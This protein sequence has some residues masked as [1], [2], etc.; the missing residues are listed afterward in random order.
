MGRPT[1]GYEFLIVD[2]ESGRLCDE[3]QPGELWVRGT[4]GIQLFLEY[5]DNPGAMA[6][7]FT[8]EG[9]F[10]TGDV[11]RIGEGGGFFFCERDKDLIKVGGE[12]VSAREVEDVIRQVP[13]LS[14]VAVVSRSHEMLD[15]VPVA[16]VIVTEGQAVDEPELEAAIIEVCS[17]KLADFKVPR[18]VHVVDEF[19]RATLDKVAKNKLRELAET[20]APREPADRGTMS[21]A[22]GGASAPNGYTKVNVW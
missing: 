18:S 21:G 19:P 13:G 20:L 10:K 16:F 6:D 15:V 7:S 12:N 8:E 17:S 3:G 14:D 4:R 22:G 11:V 5:Y 9:W 2:Q 1:P